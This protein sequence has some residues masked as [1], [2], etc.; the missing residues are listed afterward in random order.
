MSLPATMPNLTRANSVLDT[1]AKFG[2]DKFLKDY[3]F[4]LKN[5]EK[6]A[7]IVKLLSTT[8]NNPRISNGGF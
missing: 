8:V 7:S 2:N 3:E 5:R 6:A 4:Q 1:M